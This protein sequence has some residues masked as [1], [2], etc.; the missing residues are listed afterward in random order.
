M[1][2]APPAEYL[3]GSAASKRDGGSTLLIHGR[4]R[5]RARPRVRV[6][7]REREGS[8]KGLRARQSRGRARARPGIG[9]GKKPAMWVGVGRQP[10][11]IGRGFS[12]SMKRLTHLIRLNRAE[13]VAQRRIW[14]SP[15]N[16][17]QPLRRPAH[18]LA[19]LLDL[20]Q[21]LGPGDGPEV[22]RSSVPSFQRLPRSARVS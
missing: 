9:L 5:A 12:A 14:Q 1:P 11:G 6:G 22:A 7:A 20:G 15:P 4:G 16:A 8:R 3:Y 21:T 18:P 13:R 17:Q 10:W 19:Q 2:P